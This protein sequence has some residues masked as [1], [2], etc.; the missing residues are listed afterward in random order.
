MIATVVA[1]G[2]AASG[3][4]V[5]NAAAAKVTVCHLGK[6]VTVASPAAAAHAAHGDTL[7]TC[8]ASGSL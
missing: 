5:V 7:G 6:T 8:V 1:L 3:A 4:A 2:M